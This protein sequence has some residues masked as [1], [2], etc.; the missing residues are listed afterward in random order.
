M[1]HG[2]RGGPRVVESNEGA[3]FRERISTV[4]EAIA[5]S[6]GVSLT[7]LGYMTALNMA[8]VVGASTQAARSH[9]QSPASVHAP[10]HDF[11]ANLRSNSD[12]LERA[13]GWLMVLRATGDPPLGTAMWSAYGAA[14]DLTEM[15]CA[16]A[17]QESHGSPESCAMVA[18]EAATMPL[19][20][21]LSLLAADLAA[22]LDLLA[23]ISRRAADLQQLLAIGEDRGELAI[24]VARLIATPAQA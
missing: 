22:T 17:D 2:T 10:A 12:L 9:M 5:R 1:E 14:R 6:H 3:D 19:A 15:A 13:V 20:K 8:A 4:S 7:R 16:A 11:V 18:V 23:A 21:C 24:A